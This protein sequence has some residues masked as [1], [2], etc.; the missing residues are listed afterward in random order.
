FQSFSGTALCDKETLFESQL[1]CYVVAQQ[2]TADIRV[3]AV[4]GS[5]PA[6]F[7]LD[8]TLDS[9]PGAF[10]G[11]PDAPLA[12]RFGTPDLPYRG[13]V[14]HYRSFYRITQLTPGKRYNVWMTGLEDN[15][16]LFVGNLVLLEDRVSGTCVRGASSGINLDD[17]WCTFVATQDYFD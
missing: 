9:P 4:G 10:E 11:A 7:G 1:T 12:L 6:C 13:I 17:E 15:V 2:Q 3:S 14:D 5:S 8:V 16:D